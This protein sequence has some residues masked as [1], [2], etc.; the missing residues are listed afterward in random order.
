MRSMMTKAPAT[1]GGWQEENQKVMK[2]M[3][4]YVQNENTVFL[5]FF[6]PAIK[7]PEFYIIIS[8]FA[9]KMKALRIS[10]QLYTK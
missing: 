7:T 10:Q 1:S 8:L 2:H 5:M 3:E 6:L 4:T 9:S